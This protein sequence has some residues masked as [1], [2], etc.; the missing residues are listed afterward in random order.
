MDTDFDGVLRRQDMIN[1]AIALFSIVLMIIELQVAWQQD[2]LT[3]EHK[4]AIAELLKGSVTLVS[5]VLCFQLLRTY[6][7]LARIEQRSYGFDPEYTLRHNRTLQKQLALELV[8]CL[9]HT[10]PGISGLVNDKCNLIVFVRLYLLVRVV[11]DFAPFYVHRKELI[12][13]GF[14]S[15]M[16]SKINWSASLR[17]LFQANPLVFTFIVTA[18]V[19]PIFTYCIYVL[20]RESQPVLFGVEWHNSVWFACMTMANVG[21]GDIVTISWL[22]KT[23]TIISA[24]VGIVLAGIFISLVHRTLY[25]GQGQMHAYEWCIR[26]SRR[27]GEFHMA[28][29]M[30]QHA[31]RQ[32]RKRTLG[33]EAMQS[34]TETT[35]GSESGCLSPSEF[36]AVRHVF[37]R[38]RRGRLLHELRANDPRIDELLKIVNRTK[39]SNAYELK[40]L[41]QYEAGTRRMEKMWDNLRLQRKYLE[42]IDAKL[43]A[44]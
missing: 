15:V 22:G 9:V 43:D 17:T 16:M 32:H 27:R 7:R 42:A 3:L 6:Q 29:R 39:E 12:R 28:V 23:I 1:C 10:P 31:W 34:T 30:I 21:Y 40:K 36:S 4:S 19:G 35:D 24:I 2:T 26:N 8:F 13:L 20:E 37:H 25:L 11:R 18:T 14:K 5:L 33:A 44:R 41:A 38:E